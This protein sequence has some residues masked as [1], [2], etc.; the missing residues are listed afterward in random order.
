MLRNDNGTQRIYFFAKNEPRSGSPAT[1]P[2]GYK[3]EVSDRTGM[4]LLRKDP[5]AVQTGW[6]K[7]IFN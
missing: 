6:F 2:N 5:T 1:L 3:V 7:R 4:P